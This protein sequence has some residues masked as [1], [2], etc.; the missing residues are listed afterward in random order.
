MTPEKPEADDPRL[1][2]FALAIADAKPVDWEAARQSATDLDTT[3]ELPTGYTQG[4]GR[5][6]AWSGAWTA[7]VPIVPPQH[8]PARGMGDRLVLWEVDNWEWNTPPAPPGDPALLRHVGGDIY[9]VDAVW[10]LTEIERLV[11]AG[12]RP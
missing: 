10:D 9:A 4:R 5:P 3:F 7:M 1:L 12:R 6:F 2:E 11:L 8:R